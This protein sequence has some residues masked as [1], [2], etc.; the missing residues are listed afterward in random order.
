[1][2]HLRESFPTL[3]SQVDNSGVAL[4]ARTEGQTPT[5]MQGAIGFSF[6]DSAGNVVLPQLNSLGQ[7]PVTSEVN[8]NGKKARGTVNGNAAMTTVAT[9]TLTASKRY[10]NLD[11]LV[12]SFRDTHF[13]VVHNDNGTPTILADALTGPGSPSFHARLQELEFVAGASGT[14][15]LLIQ[16]QNINALS[17]MIAAFSIKENL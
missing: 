12:S 7:L 3:E 11:F 6:K 10:E 13:Q 4:A 8:G 17:D 14:Q 2:S 15:Q 16:G 5:A 9:L 1:M